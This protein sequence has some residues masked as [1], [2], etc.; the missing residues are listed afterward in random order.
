[1]AKNIFIELSNL[2]LFYV[3]R[4]KEFLPVIVTVTFCFFIF[5]CLTLLGAYFFSHFNIRKVLKIL[6]HQIRADN[7]FLENASILSLSG[8]HI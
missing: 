3:D 7:F 2:Q 5:L 6:F 4:F 1:M 8:G